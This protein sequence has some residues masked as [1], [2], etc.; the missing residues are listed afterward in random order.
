MR[1]FTSEGLVIGKRFRGY[2][3]LTTGVPGPWNAEP[4][5]I[6]EFPDELDSNK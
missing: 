5:E 1:E 3:G 6:Q 2:R 4:E